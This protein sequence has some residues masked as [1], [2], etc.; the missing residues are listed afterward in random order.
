MEGSEPIQLN[1]EVSASDATEEDT[2]RMARHRM[3]RNG[4]RIDGTGKR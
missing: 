2:D 4:C 1:I 3:V